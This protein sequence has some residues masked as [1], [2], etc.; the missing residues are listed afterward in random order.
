MY[1]TLVDICRNK[2]RYITMGKNAFDFYHAERTIEMMAQG[3]VNAIEY[4]LD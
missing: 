3:A 1:N 2:E 4:A